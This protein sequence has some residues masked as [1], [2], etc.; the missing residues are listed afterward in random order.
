[1]QT[2]NQIAQLKAEY[3]EKEAAAEREADAMA[4]EVRALRQALSHEIQKSSRL[5]E[6]LEIQETT[7][8]GL[9]TKANA[10]ERALTGLKEH[11][12]ALNELHKEHTT[13]GSELSDIRA[14]QERGGHGIDKRQSLVEVA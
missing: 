8:E 5:Q 6:K 9:E 1:M 10:G 14:A 12:R 4:S 13:L 11:K 7:M 2:K 3:S